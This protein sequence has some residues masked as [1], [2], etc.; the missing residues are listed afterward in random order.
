M[1]LRVRPVVGV[2]G[3]PVGSRRLAVLP[4]LDRPTPS[5]PRPSSLTPARMAAGSTATGNVRGKREW[6]ATLLIRLALM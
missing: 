3:V 1:M 6:M 2:N 5:H 4:K